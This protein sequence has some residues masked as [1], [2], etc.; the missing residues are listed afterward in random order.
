MLNWHSV[1]ELYE[2]PLDK[3]W[4]T[5]QDNLHY[6]LY[7]ILLPI[8]VTLITIKINSFLKRRALFNKFPGPKLHPFWGSIKQFRNNENGIRA[9]EN[10]LKENMHDKF[11]R[12]RRGPSFYFISV[13]DPELAGKV[14]SMGYDLAPK[15]LTT[16]SILSSFLGYGLLIINY[17]KWFSRRR[18][19]TP[20]FH[21]GIIESY[22]SIYNETTDV[23]LNKWNSLVDDDSTTVDV[24][25]HSTLYTLDVILRCAC[26][27]ESNCQVDQSGGAKEYISAIFDSAKLSVEQIVYVPNYLP[28]YFRLS[29]S[30]FRWRE[31]CR[32]IKEESLKI[33]QARRKAIV[34]GEK[35][36]KSRPDFIDI[37][38]T[39]QDASGETLSDSDIMSEMN[40]FLFEG[41][42]TTASGVSWTLYMMGLHPDIQSQ[43]RE[44]IRSVLG[45]RQRVEW[46]DLDSLKFTSLCIKESMRLF[47]PVPSITRVLNEDLKVADYVIP[48]GTPVNIPIFLLH[49]HPKYWEHPD[50][51]DPNRF[52]EEK[53]GGSNFSYIPFSAGHRNCIGQKF[54]LTE[55]L[56]VVARVIHRF[57]L[58]SV[59]NEAKR[60]SQLILKSE[61]G[62]HVKIRPIK[63]K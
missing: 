49:R 11:V 9:F 34:S 2:T 38:L 46:E 13:L 30:G 62:L 10:Y 39:S 16:Y 6:F 45:E 43:C 42:D 47:P 24:F 8:A 1:I 53:P 7:Y 35:V 60:L 36:V 17:K 22:V 56:I 27:Y 14:L 19:L 28:L 55:E 33:V 21:N 15:S 50:K 40:T 12:L 61:G 63:L 31:V 48:R 41:H 23:L 26:S 37:L 58:E 51:F 32:R 29:P 59:P 54:A 3:M 44:E 20:A 5:L 52:L 57:E 25:Q 4:E 18:L